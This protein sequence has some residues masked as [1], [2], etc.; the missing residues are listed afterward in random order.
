MER[1]FEVHVSSELDGFYVLMTAA[2]IISRYKL[3][4]PAQAKLEAMQEGEEIEVDQYPI[5]NLQIVATGFF[6][7]V[8]EDP[9]RDWWLDLRI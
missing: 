9:E 7:E 2:E 6:D 4:E 1:L 3:G 5:E 8:E